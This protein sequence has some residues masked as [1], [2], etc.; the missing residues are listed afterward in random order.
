MTE[1]R[2]RIDWRRSDICLAAARHPARS[3]FSCLRGKADTRIRRPKSLVS[4]P[5]HNLEEKPFLKC[6]GI[7]LEEL[8]LVVSIVK[9]SIFLH[10]FQQ[11]RIELVP[12]IDVIIIVV[13]N[14]QKGSACRAYG[15]YGFED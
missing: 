1:T 9:N 10:R 2:T 6:V 11:A 13:R 8:S 7:D 12:A 4:T 5:L 15:R 3:R 14:L